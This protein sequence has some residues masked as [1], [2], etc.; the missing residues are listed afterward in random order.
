MPTASPRHP[1]CALSALSTSL[2]CCCHLTPTPPRQQSK[3]SFPSSP[4]Q[5]LLCSA[6]ALLLCP[7]WRRSS[8]EQSSMRRRC[9]SYLEQRVDE[10]LLP[11]HFTVRHPLLRAPPHGQHT[12]VPIRSSRHLLKSRLSAVK[13]SVPSDAAMSHWTAPS[14]MFPADHILP[15]WGTLLW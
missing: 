8:N 7:P 11:G 15:S 4:R 12:H 1:S 3:V 10:A 6:L 5:T 13:S 9:T 2:P 14:P